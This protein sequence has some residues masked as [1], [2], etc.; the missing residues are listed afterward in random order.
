[1]AVMGTHVI[2]LDIGT[3]AVRAVEL[4][5]GRGRPV[6]KRMGQVALPL[7]A[8]VTGEVV[9]VLAVA[10][11]L[12]RLWKEGGFTS[13][14]VVV[15]VANPRVVARMA[16]LPELP[17]DELRS[18]LPYQV[19]D[20]IPIP[21]EEAELDFHVVERDVGTDGEALIRV[22][23]V[24]AHKDM[25]RSLLAALDGAGLT[26]SRIDL[27]PFALIRALHD[28][29]TWLSS[30]RPLGG[31]EVIIGSG[32]G[33]TNV[34]VHENGVPKFVRT[35]PTGGAAVTDALAL[36]LGIPSDDAESLK[37][38]IGAGTYAA[39]QPQVESV[40]QETLLPLANE[41]A[42][43]LDFH[44]AQVGHGELR[45][46][47]MCGGAGRLRALRSVLQDQ[48]GVTV[49][50]GDPY[51]GLDL[52]SVPLDP[53]IVAASGDVFAVAIGLAL[54]GEPLHG[55]S[56][57]ISLLPAAITEKRAERRQLVTAGAGVGGLAV[58]LVALALVRGAQV[59]AVEDDALQAE[60]RAD[61]LAAEAD[62]LDEVEQLQGD[63]AQRGRTVTAA[64]QGD[65]AWPRVLRDVAAVMPGEVW[66]TSFTGAAR[67]GTLQFAANGA[68]H[69]SAARWL[70]GIEGL[71]S[72]EAPW[73]ASSTKGERGVQFSASA[74]LT[75]LAGSDRA[76]RYSEEQP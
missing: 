72:V 10:T 38:G 60:R 1:M 36:D 28:P 25:L 44:L 48:L 70:E 69:P 32:A 15:G 62:S 59:G 50:D 71:D 33:V 76:A 34:V 51:S 68:E 64:L 45:R 7:G 73:V 13:R 24:A 31:H 29:A 49:V 8:V 52:R 74:R 54:S 56:R 46:V 53:A 11:A 19:Q 14:S 12:R 6:V 75:E 5:T 30:D 55:E 20:L 67:E 35:L 37:R 40:A 23:L 27:I 41:V 58:A 26:A 4:V 65:V 22:L 17:D 57:R 2:G 47:V 9:D 61:V 63:I 16:D 21:V 3:N 39:D 18:S 66:L 42:G 43:S